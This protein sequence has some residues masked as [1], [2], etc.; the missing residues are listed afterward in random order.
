MAQLETMNM[1]E[2]TYWRAFYRQEGLERMRQSE[3]AVAPEAFD[4][5]LERM[6]RGGP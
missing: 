4:A 5:E 3:G 2:L 6:Q 1:R